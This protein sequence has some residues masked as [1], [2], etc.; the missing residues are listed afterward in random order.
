MRPV[1]TSGRREGAEP[2]AEGGRREG[3]REAAEAEVGVAVAG[4]LF[5]SMSTSPTAEA[6]PLANRAAEE[7]STVGRV[8]DPVPFEADAGVMGR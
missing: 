4:E 8:A 5:H 2:L 3:R 1:F 6:A 7:V